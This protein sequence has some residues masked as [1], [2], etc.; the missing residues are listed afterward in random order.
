MEVECLTDS[1]PLS[2]VSVISVISNYIT[3]VLRLLKQLFQ[4]VFC[5]F[6]IIFSV[7]FVLNLF[8]WGKG[9]S[10]AIPFTT[11]IALL[12]LWF[13]ISVPLTFVGAYFGFK[14]R[15]SVMD[16]MS[17]CRCTLLYNFSTSHT[18]RPVLT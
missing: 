14:K 18:S 5:N 8:L 2:H 10:A 1:I 11:L 17:D 3:T 7:F 4:A 12:A 16:D 9:S 13:G 15:V 6:R